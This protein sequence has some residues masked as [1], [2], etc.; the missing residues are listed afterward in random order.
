MLSVPS[1][2]NWCGFGGSDTKAAP[3]EGCKKGKS[4]APERRSGASGEIWRCGLRGLDVR[5]G[6]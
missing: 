6:V 3:L 4:G 5:V 1:L 2:E